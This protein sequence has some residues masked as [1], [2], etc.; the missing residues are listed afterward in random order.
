M[1]LEIN[2]KDYLSE[3]EIKE[4]CKDTIRNCIKEKLNKEEDIQRFLTN[5]SYHFVWSAVEELCPENMKELITNKIPE[6]IKGLS[7]YHVFRKKDVW[8]K[9]E[10]KGWILLQ[11]ALSETEPLIKERVCELINEIGLRDIQEILN[12]KIENIIYNTQN[13]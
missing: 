8:D 2:I 9:D 1:N 5:S 11:K 6:I 13:K 12:E 7:T 10:S 3:E 4:V